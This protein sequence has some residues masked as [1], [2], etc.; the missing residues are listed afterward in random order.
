MA[1]TIVERFCV[2]KHCRPKDKDGKPIKPI[3]IRKFMTKALGQFRDAE[4]LHC[5]GCGEK[6][7][8]L[9]TF[10]TK[11]EYKAW[12][13]KEEAAVRAVLDK[14]KEKQRSD[15]MVEATT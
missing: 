13:E 10:R 2:R 9:T 4:Q 11:K 12:K 14:V 15:A 8:E 3:I 5:G 1:T 7:T 6:W